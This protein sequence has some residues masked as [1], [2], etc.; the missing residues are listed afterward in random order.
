MKLNVHL[1]VWNGGKYIPF[2]FD[3][4]KKQSFTDW[5][6][7]ILDNGS[8]DKTVSEIKKQIIDFPVEVEL[9]E[10]K[11]NLGFA[12]G[13]N[14][15]VESRKSKVKSQYILLVNQDM[16][17]EEDCLEKMVK[18]MNENQDCAVV[19]PRLMKWDFGGMQNAERRMQNSFTNKIDSL[20]L[21][22]LRSRRVIEKYTG[23]DWDEKKSRLELSHRT[24]G[25]TMEVFGV[26]GAI[27]LFRRSV[28]E[29]VGLFDE[30]FVSYK[31]DVDLAFR[32][33]S[34]GYKAFV[35]LDAVAYHDRS[36]EGVEKM[37]GKNKKNQSDLVKYYSYR[38][39]LITILKNEYWQNYLLDFFFIEWYELKKFVWFLL[40]DRGVLRGLRDIIKISEDLKIKRLKIKKLRKVSW[41]EMRK[42]FR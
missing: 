33:C 26:S 14:T 17:L 38:N 4:L 1:V 3:S 7:F 18:F 9:I 2:L 27:P 34:A 10:N 23:K 29:E 15:L 25:Q 5:K 6:L 30:S 22:V 41:R 13:H 28:I 8:T 36:A 12:K 42:W 31:E 20:G 19:S 37:S 35:L 40:F 39:H 11:E 24:Q 21:K 16:Y 32:L